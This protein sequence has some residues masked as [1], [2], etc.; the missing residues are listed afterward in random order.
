[1]Q[2]NTQSLLRSQQ[3]TEEFKGDYEGTYVI[4]NLG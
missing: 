3:S 4:S 1:M 2:I